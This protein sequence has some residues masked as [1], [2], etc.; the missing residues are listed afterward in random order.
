MCV[1]DETK[2][3]SQYGDNVKKDDNKASC[4]SIC[5]RDSLPIQ[6]IHLNIYDLLGGHKVRHAGMV[7][8]PFEIKKSETSPKRPI[9]KKSYSRVTPNSNWTPKRCPWVV[10]PLDQLHG[11]CSLDGFI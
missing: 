3:R 4:S 7:K 1:E 8:W 9:N 2:P 5:S 6:S 11:I 10:D